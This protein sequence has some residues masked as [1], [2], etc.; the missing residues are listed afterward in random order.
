MQRNAECLRT[1]NVGETRWVSN[2]GVGDEGLLRVGIVIDASP[3]ASL[4]QLQDHGAFSLNVAL[5]QTLHA[6]DE[7]W[8]LYHICHQFLRI[9]TDGIEVESRFPDERV[10]NI[11]GRQSHPMAVSLQLLAERNE[12]CTSPRLPTTCM[13][14][15]S[16]TL[17]VR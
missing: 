14:T 2:D 10:E 8:I 11:M 9:A 4:E 6:Q 3:P 12:G 16:R 13:T 1:V 17:Q 5:A 15:F 7:S